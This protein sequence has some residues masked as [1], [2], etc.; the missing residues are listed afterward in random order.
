MGGMLWSTW[1][2][3]RGIEV[4]YRRLRY[5]R[6]SH[7]GVSALWADHFQHGVAD[8]GAPTGI[9]H[10]FRFESVHPDLVVLMSRW[11][12]RTGA[13]LLRELYHAAPDKD[14]LVPVL[15]NTAFALRDKHPVCARALDLD[16]LHELA[17]VSKD[18][19]DLAR[20][21]S[22][23]IRFLDI[24]MPQFFTKCNV[25]PNGNALTEQLTAR[26]AACT[27]IEREMLDQIEADPKNA[28]LLP[29]Y[30]DWLEATGRLDDATAVRARL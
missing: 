11:S 7:S 14:A 3:V 17:H 12:D 24:A 18:L 15:H 5:A 25:L 30:A 19:G 9:E 27:G 26:R 13:S 6:W 23:R 20:R 29:V 2:S 4:T 16:V 22:S 1:R 10:A 21:W 28:T 8:D